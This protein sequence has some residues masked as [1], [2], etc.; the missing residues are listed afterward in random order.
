MENQ[1]NPPKPRKKRRV[2]SQFLAAIVIMAV[3]AGVVSYFWL[4]S[5]RAPD[6]PEVISTDISQ[7]VD[8]T[9]ETQGDFTLSDVKI[10]D[11][12]ARIV[13]S[14]QLTYN[15][16]EPTNARLT[17]T[18]IYTGNGQLQGRK[19]LEITDIQPNEQRPLEVSI[20]GEFGRRD[21]YKLEIEKI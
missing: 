12:G 18:L 14:A 21:S 3:L 9:A 11:I 17:F 6:K 15:G 10:D 1:P 20:I 19:Y 8:Q 2:P 16:A 4:F 7:L 13:A 5:N